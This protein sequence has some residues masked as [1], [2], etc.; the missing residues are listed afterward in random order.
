MKNKFVEAALENV[1]DFLREGDQV[2]FD[3]NHRNGTA[4]IL[5]AYAKGKKVFKKIMALTP[6]TYPDAI[7]AEDKVYNIV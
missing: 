6:E 1:S 5:V 2:S 4:L 3:I 7:K